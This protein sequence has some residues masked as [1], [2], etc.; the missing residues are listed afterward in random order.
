MEIALVLAVSQKSM[1]IGGHTHERAAGA[2]D[3]YLYAGHHDGHMMEGRQ[4]EGA[5]CACVA[6][7]LDDRCNTRPHVSVKTSTAADCLAES[8]I[9]QTN[10]GE[11]LSRLG[12]LFFFLSEL[13]SFVVLFHHQNISKSV[14]LK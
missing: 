6:H 8:L 3:T 13:Q 9:Q 14:C 12:I 4:D 1:S 2:G 11:I 5:N 7:E 10:D